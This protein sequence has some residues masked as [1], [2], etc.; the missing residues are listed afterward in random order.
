MNLMLGM[1]T[2]ET[3]TALLAQPMVCMHIKSLPAGWVHAHCWQERFPLAG[4]FGSDLVT[5]YLVSRSLIIPC[6]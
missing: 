6:A 3:N 2:V 5:S 4:D 1:T